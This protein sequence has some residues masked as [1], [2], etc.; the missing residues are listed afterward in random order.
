[1]YTLQ[2]LETF[3]AGPLNLISGIDDLDLVAHNG[4]LML[5]AGTR[6][7]GGVVALDV[8]Q[9]MTLVNTVTFSV[10]SQLP[11]GA[12]LDMIVVSGQPR[13]VVSGSNQ[14]AVLTYR[15]QADGGIGGAVKLPNSLN[16]VISA[17]AVVETGPSQFFYAVRANEGLIRAYSLTSSGAASL[18]GTI[19]AS[20]DDQG[21]QISRLLDLTVGGNHV[22]VA[23]S[24]NTDA[25][26]TYRVQVDGSLVAAEALGAAQGLALADPSHVSSFSVLGR[27]YLVVASA[28]NS[29]IS[30]VEVTSSGAMTV[31]DHVSDTLDTRFQGVRAVETVMIGNRAFVIAGGGD[32]GLNVFEVMP[33][34]RLVVVAVYLDTPGV[35]LE[36][37]SAI[38]AQVVNGTIEIFV[39]GEGTGISRLTMT[40]GPQ[41]DP[42]IGGAEDDTLTGGATGDMICGGAGNDVISGG[43][44]ADILVDGTGLDTMS[45]GAGADIFVLSSDGQVDVISDFQLGID[46]I[47]L[48]AWGAIHD[49]SA[50]TLTP[51]ATGILV[52]YRGEVLDIRSANGLPIGAGALQRQDLFPLWHLASMHRDSDGAIRGTDAADYLHGT[53]QDDVFRWSDGS[54]TIV[55][56]AGHDRVDFTQASLSIYLDFEVQSANAGAS[57]GQLLFG[58]EAVWATAFADTIYGSALAD[59]LAGGS[60]DDTI[61][62]RSGNDSLY[63]GEGR[64]ALVGGVGADYLDGGPGEDVAGFWNATVGQIIDMENPTAQTGEAAGDVFVNIERI[65]GSAWGDT[66]SGD[67]NANILDGAGGN[68][69]LVGRGGNDTLIGGSGSDALLGG[70][71]ADLLQ[72]GSGFDQAAYWYA[73]SGVTVDLLNMAGNTGEAAGDVFQGIEGL[74]G[75]A[76]ADALSGD[77]LGN[78]LGGYNGNDTLSGRGGS[79]TLM[80]ENGNDILIGGEGAD[81]LFGGLGQDHVGYWGAATGVTADLLSPQYNTGEAAGDIFN[82][83][84]NLSGTALADVLW[85]DDAANYL[86]GYLGD[87]MLHG[88]A[89]NDYL[90]GDLGNDVLNGGGG[91]DVLDGGS[92]T[93]QA[94]YWYAA[95]G[96]TVSL[97]DPLLNTAEAAGDQFIGIDGLSGSRFAD[98]LIGDFAANFVNGY[99]G[100]D[101]LYGS[102]GNDTL[103]GDAGNDTL[104]GGAGDDFLHGGAG[105]DQFV[106]NG[107]SDVVMDFADNVDTLAIDSGLWGGAARDVA[108][109]LHQAQVVNGSVVFSFGAHWVTIAGIASIQALADDLLIL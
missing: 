77:N 25:I 75:S 64:D 80:G 54:D 60:G 51:T 3:T 59:A 32:G 93:D 76:F 28:S 8:D 67:D 82:S 103:M 55:G 7:G 35:A 63:G 79:D 83:I 44:G 16:G 61:A 49:I 56:D 101:V 27:S 72:G 46:R 95:S 39:A 92:G 107:G 104:H 45:G 89:G 34:G 108:W 22:L 6:S 13:I 30:V 81:Y 41:S 98:I 31:T 23:L 96:V 4:N 71:G 38:A 10:T 78:F 33:D 9:A 74:S 26:L 94:V 87:D 99:L 5:Y 73:T 90:A 40:P 88:R 84:E 12:T 36:S 18:I 57:A 62:G 97:Y 48:G 100:D 17:Q 91:A 14:S 43:A 20:P 68:N 66:I 106:F 2:H 52:S 109:V 29:A 69:R 50:L 53:A 11:V 15:L 24:L 105:A 70:T 102:L 42:Q 37:V 85:G 19:Q 65:V 21:V 58:I 86:G 1:M 47:D